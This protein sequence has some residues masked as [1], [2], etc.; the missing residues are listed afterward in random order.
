M[1]LPGYD[2]LKK[3]C[4]EAAPEGVDTREGSLFDTAVGPVCA[5][6]AAAYLTLQSFYDLLFPDTSAGAYLDRI[7]A[8]YGI[9]RGT[10]S[11]AVL[12]AEFT[13]QQGGD[14]TVP[15]GMRFSLSGVFYLVEE[16]WLGGGRLRCETAGEAGNQLGE[17]L[18]CDYLTGF[19]RAE[20]VSLL[21]PG[22][23]EEG[24][25]PLRQRVLELL[26]YPAF[27]GNVS[28]YKEKVRAVPGVGGVRVTPVVLGGGTV[29]VE[30][31]GSDFNPAGESL[32]EDVRQMLIPG[33]QADGLGMAPIGHTVTVSAPAAE[34][35]SL[36]AGI[37]T[38]GDPD[39]VKA[40]AEAAASGYLKSLRQKWEDEDAVVRY[41][42][43]MAA[44]SG[45]EGVVD[46]SNL[47]I[48]GGTANISCDGVPVDGTFS[49]T[50]QDLE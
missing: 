4:L 50:V 47:L 40:A 23:E 12:E 17:L 1:E 44:L 5:E 29:G 26:A 39:A 43:M 31:L 36:S 15:V 28:D 37:L 7:A 45:A 34:A 10:A 8:Q 42:G 21:T 25:G 19:G 35:V 9:S 14:F 30:V 3:Q 6:L 18:P 24:D 2:E 13:D 38:G 20:A 49:L 27:G 46:V 32:L 22:E 48:N 33:Y 41:S 16:S 11:P